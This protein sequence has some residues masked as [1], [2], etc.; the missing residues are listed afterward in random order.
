MGFE[1][2]LSSLYRQIAIRCWYIRAS[3]TAWSQSKFQFCQMAKLTCHSG[4]FVAVFESILWH[5]NWTRPDV[6]AA[7]AIFG[8]K[9]LIHQFNVDVDTLASVFPPLAVLLDSLSS[10]QT[11]VV[12]RKRNAMWQNK[13]PSVFHYFPFNGALQFPPFPLYCKL[14]CKRLLLFSTA[15]LASPPRVNHLVIHWCDTITRQDF[16]FLSEKDGYIIIKC[17]GV[18]DSSGGRTLDQKIQAR[19]A[20]MGFFSADPLTVFKQLPRAVAITNICANV[21]KPQ[22]LASIPLFGLGQE[23]VLHTLV[24][25]SAFAASVQCRQ[26]YC[27]VSRQLH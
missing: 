26:L 11:I 19:N 10:P 22:E 3:F 14:S 13:P 12:L 2:R 6:N 16:S 25:S 7:S 24:G 5:L 15:M 4:S 8:T 18:W 20:N 21:L 23:W 27:Q 17:S 1:S 9:P